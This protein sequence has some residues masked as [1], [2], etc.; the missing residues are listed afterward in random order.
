MTGNIF[1]GVQYFFKGI[2][3]VL[4]PG[5][6]RYI[7]VPLI[8]NIFLLLG[9][10]FG[11]AFLITTY[12]GGFT[13][14]FKAFPQ[15][16]I[17]LFGWLFWILYTLISV[18]L[19]TLMFTMLTNLIASPFYGLLSEAVE[20]TIEHRPIANT[21]IKDFPAL[22]YHT[23]MRELRKL[24]Y[25]TPWLFLSLVLLILP[26][27]WPLFP[28]VWFLVMSWI[29]AIQYCDYPADN[30]KIPLKQMI[31]T[32]KTVPLTALGFGGMVSL[33]LAVPG[34]NLIIP[35]AAVAGGTLLWQN[36]KKRLISQ[37]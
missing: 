16:V 13:G 12:M 26:L 28:I 31:K 1:H 14:L 23:F 35:A 32:I 29:M 11:A 19:G 2:H 22:W 37:Q 20:L 8:I 30:Q 3:L 17:L 15:W 21:A 36:L 5:L 9:I 24:W 33:A 27:T 7:L 4:S 34:L 18:M 6:K 10:I 25:F